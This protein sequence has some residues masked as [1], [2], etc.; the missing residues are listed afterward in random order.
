MWV[1]TGNTLSQ[2]LLC[3][4]LVQPPTLPYLGMVAA[5]PQRFLPQLGALL[6]GAGASTRSSFSDLNR[7]PLEPPLPMCLIRVTLPEIWAAGVPG[8]SCATVHR[9]MLY[10]VV[11]YR[12]PGVPLGE[13]GAVGGNILDETGDGIII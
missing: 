8:L 6:E 9:G 4:L 13:A 12:G 10:P 1:L 11:G 5:R 2:R 7:S 3:T